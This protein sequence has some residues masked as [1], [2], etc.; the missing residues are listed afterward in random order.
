MESPIRI[1]DRPH[2][3][4]EQISSTVRCSTTEQLRVQCDTYWGT[5]L[6]WPT[7]AWCHME[8]ARANVYENLFSRRES[9]VAA[10]LN[11]WNGVLRYFHWVSCGDVITSTRRSCRTDQYESGK[12]AIMSP[13]ELIHIWIWF[14]GI[15]VYLKWSIFRLFPK[16]WRSNSVY[17]TDASCNHITIF[18]RH[19]YSINKWG[20]TTLCITACLFFNL[21]CHNSSRYIHPWNITCND[22]VSILPSN[23]EHDLNR[24]IYLVS[25]IRQLGFTRRIFSVAH[26]H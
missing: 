7:P 24:I 8:C 10:K 6:I 4:F 3:K 23:F 18:T 26:F 15:T 2:K 21:N 16:Q 14:E 17:K 1:W 13:T 20:Y 12:A 19:N 22:A 25:T 9:C 5:V 11:N